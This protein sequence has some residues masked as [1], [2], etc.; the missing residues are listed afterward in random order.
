MRFW[1]SLAGIFTVLA[2]A[3]SGC[4]STGT[5]T[6]LYAGA[7]ALAAAN[8]GAAAVA[9][10]TVGCIFQG[11]PYGSYCN[12][13]SRMCDVRKCA[14]G[15]PGGTVCNEGLDRCQAPGPPKTPNDRQPQDNQ[16]DQFFPPL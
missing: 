11:C 6:A 8:A 13:E 1:P 16:L 4:A 2:V 7:P 12:K 5:T 9:S 15:C 14:D 3:V 10:V